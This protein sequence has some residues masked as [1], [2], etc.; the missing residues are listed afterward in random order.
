MKSSTLI[1]LLASALFAILVFFNIWLL[2]SLQDQLQVYVD[3]VRHLADHFFEYEILSILIALSAALLA[4]VVLQRLVSLPL[5][6]LR[7][8][9]YRCLKQATY[10]PDKFTTILDELKALHKLNNRLYDDLTELEEDFEQSVKEHTKAL[11]REKSFVAEIIN[12]IDDAIFVS[13]GNKIIRTNASFEQVFGTH[14]STD[15]LMA[16]IEPPSAGSH[17]SGISY[18]GRCYSVKEVTLE[19]DYVITTLSDV[20]DYTNEIRLAKDQNPLSGLP[21]NQSIGNYLQDILAKPKAATLVYFDFD[22]F[23][24]FNDNYGFE[25]GD[26][27][28]VLFAEILKSIATPFPFFMGH[29]GGD[30]FF[31]SFEAPFSQ[32]L[33]I[34]EIIIERFS[35]AAKQLYRESDRRRGYVEIKDRYGVVRRFELLGVSASIL[36]KTPLSKH[37]DFAKLSSILAPL[38]KMAKV[39]PCRIAALSLL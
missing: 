1:T 22:N 20:T 34:T 39:S 23:K 17:E 13:Q 3:D 21:G 36:E 29:V 35:K 18:R 4:N 10:L 16:L 7:N 24:P 38:K 27:A 8:N 19:N 12:R 2:M 30:D 32:A 9:A 14:D 6:H 26:K 15:G 33:P 25:R 11:E 28:I 5:E 37:T 31:C